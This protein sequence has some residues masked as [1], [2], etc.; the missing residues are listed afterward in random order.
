MVDAPYN[1]YPSYNE[2]NV[3]L[4][5][6]FEAV[7]SANERA[8]NAMQKGLAGD[9]ARLL[10]QLKSVVS[11]AHENYSISGKLSWAE[12]QRYERIK[13][14]EEQVDKAIKDNYS[15]I[16]KR[17][18]SDQKKVIEQTYD[19]S[20]QA[21]ISAAELGIK[22]PGLTGARIQEILNK[23]WSGVSLA[24]RMYLRQTYLGIQLKGS[25]RRGTLGEGETFSESMKN[26]KD[27]V[28]KDYAGTKRVAEDSAHQY[29]SDTTAEAL[30]GLSEKEIE[31]TKTWVTA[32][33]DR[34]RPSHVDMDGQTVLASEQFEFVS[35]DNKGVKTEAPGISASDEDWGCRC[36]V[37]A[38]IR[39]KGEE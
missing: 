28:T 10:R 31:L 13:K 2:Q 6:A 17:V 30:K 39:K 29:Q 8:I 35:G 33:D 22:P 1:P 21:V 38:G 34:V 36:W 11:A 20:V 18:I 7:V 24:E 3:R 25:I 27:Y 32:G 26:I 14:L 12:L 23:P 19:G 4:H 5:K 37:V 16:R 9:Y 15:N